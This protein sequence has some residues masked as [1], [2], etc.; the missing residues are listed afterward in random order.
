MVMTVPMAEEWCNSNTSC[1]GFTYLTADGT[2]ADKATNI[3]F[4]DETQIFFMDSEV[5]GLSVGAAVVV[6]VGAAVVV[7]V[8]AVAVVVVVGAAVIVVVVGAT[9]AVVVVVGAAVAVVVV[10]EEE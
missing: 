4:R 1:H 8:G 5:H 10:E 7:V 2:A 9:V 3:Y 6:V